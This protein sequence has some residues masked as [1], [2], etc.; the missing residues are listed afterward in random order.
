MEICIFSA[1]RVNLLDDTADITQ[2]AKPI[3]WR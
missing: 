3:K 2:T 1:A